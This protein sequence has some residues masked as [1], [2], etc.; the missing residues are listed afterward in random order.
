MLTGTTFSM[1]LEDRNM[2]KIN[3]L[4][5]IRTLV[6]SS[7]VKGDDPA[8][9]IKF[10]QSDVNLRKVKENP[11]RSIFRITGKNGKMLY[12]KFF[13]KQKFPFNIIRFYAGKE[14]QIAKLLQKSSLP[15]INYIAW[16]TL[17]NGGGFCVSE[18]LPEAISGRQYFFQIARFDAKKKQI[19]LD[20]IAELT[21][22]L[23]KKNFY[24]SDFHTSNFLFDMSTEKVCLV[25]PWG[26]RKVIFFPEF[27]KIS[28]C[29]PWL[30][31][32]DYL[33]DDEIVKGLLSSS[34][35]KN[36]FAAMELLEHARTTYCRQQE[37]HWPKI[38]QR[39]LGGKSKFATLE[40]RGNDRY[41]WRHTQWF[42]QP[43][44]FEIDPA[45]KMKPYSDPAEAERI[46]LDSFR[47]YC[48]D[49]PVLRIVHPD[50][51]SELYFC[52]NS[53]TTST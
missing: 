21:Y 2:D 27:R 26:I 28:M 9:V 25:D 32:Q 43:D 42:T 51:S 4:N 20:Q 3:S 13:K 14:Y 1:E 35:V 30:E 19:F 12:F 23:Y 15:I 50:H 31:L 5:D 36:K 45:W 8:G 16:A 47:T 41:Y 7:S 34:L 46:W 38:K 48:R 6:A 22:S 49:L 11:K 44:K 33:T 17:K 39:I 52:L 29:S 40:I 10:I 53:N 18:G 37:L 24:H